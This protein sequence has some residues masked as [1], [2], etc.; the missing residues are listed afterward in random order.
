MSINKL[1]ANKHAHAVFIVILEDNRV[2]N[3]SLWKGSSRWFRSRRF[4]AGYFTIYV[5]PRE[6]VKKEISAELAE[7]TDPALTF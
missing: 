6:V 2:G 7:Q 4:S 1:L 5:P 3:L